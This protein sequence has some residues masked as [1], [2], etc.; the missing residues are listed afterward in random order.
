MKLYKNKFRVDSTRLKDWDYS[1]TVYYFVI[2]CT[3][4]HVCFFGEVVEGEM[5]LTSLG[6]VALKS[7]QEIPHHFPHVKLDAFVVMPNHIHGIVI[8]ESDDQIVETQN[9]A[10]LQEFQPNKFGP[11][12]KN[13][14]SIIRGYKIGV[15]KWSTINKIPFAWQERFYDHII[16]NE[17]DLNDIREYIVNNPLNWEKDEENKGKIKYAETQN[18]ASLHE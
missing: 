12:S 9:F 11:Q 7:W 16:R 3:K 15:K 14:A 6:V 8:I 18:F 10:S 17:D 1:S 4:R 13:L 5:K 2:I